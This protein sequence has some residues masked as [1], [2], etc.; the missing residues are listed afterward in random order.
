MDEFTQGVLITGVMKMVE[1]GE[2][3]IVGPP[4]LMTEDQV[5]FAVKGVL[6]ERGYDV[7]VAWGHARGV[8]LEARK[9]GERRLLIEAKGDAPTPQQQGT[10]FLG[11][12]GELVQRMID[13]DAE[14]GL[15]LPDNAR[16]RGLV[17]RLPDLAAERLH[18]HVFFV[19]R[20]PDQ[21]MVRWSSWDD[22][23]FQE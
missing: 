17:Q 7:T 16:Y 22:S 10:Y 9:R 2:P 20:E 5:K 12:L 11:A 14:Y 13:P 8:D 19:T 3:P 18:L 21:W 23:Q 6:E 4:T 15:A 1:T